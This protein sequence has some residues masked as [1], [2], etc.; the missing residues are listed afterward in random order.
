[1]AALH[2]YL[3]ELAKMPLFKAELA[4]LKRYR[5]PKQADEQ[6]PSVRR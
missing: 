4:R 5:A 6:H 3:G 1:M 2:R